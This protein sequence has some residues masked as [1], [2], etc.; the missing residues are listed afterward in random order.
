MANF[1]FY[2][3]ESFAPTDLDRLESRNR[4]KSKAE[5][6]AIQR[7]NKKANKLIE[8]K[9]TLIYL[10]VTYL[11]KKMKVSSGE[12]VRLRD[13]D[14]SKERPKRNVPLSMR[15]NEIQSKAQQILEYYKRDKEIPSVDEFKERIKEAFRPVAKRGDFLSDLESYLEAKR[16]HLVPGTMKVKEQLRNYLM[17]FQN[18]TRY[19]L[20]YDRINQSF[21]GKFV[22]FLQTEDPTVNKQALNNNTIGKQ[23]AGLK[24]FLHYATEQGWN[25]NDAFLR[26]KAPK[27]AVHNIHLSPEELDII[28]ELDLSERPQL[29]GSRDLFLL[30]CYTGL[31]FSDFTQLKEENFAIE[32]GK[33]LLSVVSQ[34]TRSRVVIPVHPR[35]KQILA[36]HGGK[37]PRSIQNQPL[38]RNLKTIGKLAGLNESVELVDHSGVKR[39]SQTKPKY[40]LI[41][42]HTARRSFATNL[43]QAGV[44]PAFI[45][46]VT[47]HK[48]ESSFL[49]YIKVTEQDVVEQIIESTY[50]QQS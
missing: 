17:L 22:E 35:I 34:K 1:H 50:F 24:S 31:R 2:L 20:A 45:M 14:F 27:E 16:P 25:S 41:V 47:G 11:G 29:D 23:I 33:E 9:E 39:R 18:Q 7:E 48:T 28:Y 4:D 30:G 6:Q 32:N 42:S 21:Y 13:W 38:N 40:E 10:V 15:L 8:E 43:Y 44:K 46:R 12:K 26:F 3:K 37:P 36:K 19:R 5:I 49:R